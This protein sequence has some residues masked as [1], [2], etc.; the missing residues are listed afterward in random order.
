MSELIP[1]ISDP[2]WNEN[3]RRNDPGYHDYVG[4]VNNYVMQSD[5]TLLILRPNQLSGAA[6]KL[7]ANHFKWAKGRCAWPRRKI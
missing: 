7:A 4:P 6:M 5:G 2:D 1:G 3:Q